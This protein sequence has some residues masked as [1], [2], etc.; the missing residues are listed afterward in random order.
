MT[1]LHIRAFV[2]VLALSPIAGLV[3]ALSSSIGGFS[4]LV[5]LGLAA[6]PLTLLATVS[7]ESFAAFAL[8]ATQPL[9][10]LQLP[11][12]FGNLT[13]GIGVLIVI[14]LRWHSEILSC[15]TQRGLALPLALAAAF[16]AGRLVHLFHSPLDVTLREFPQAASY[17]AAMAVGLWVASRR[18]LGYVAVG[19]AA[20]LLVMALIAAVSGVQLL[21]SGSHAGPARALF[22]VSSPLARGYGLP[23]PNDATALLLPLAVPWFVWVI[24]H[25]TSRRQRVAATLLLLSLSIAVVFVFQSR[26]MLL[27]LGVAALFGAALWGRFRLWVTATTV[28]MAM[29]VLL[30]SGQLDSV[31]PA[32]SELRLDGFRTAASLLTDG[33]EWVAV[34]TGTE[35]IY[36]RFM[37]L[38]YWGRVFEPGLAFQP[39]HNLILN[40]LVHS[41]IVVAGALLGLWAVVATRLW[42]V[43]DLVHSSPYWF[44]A[45]VGLAMTALA[46]QFDPISSN[47][48]SMWLVLGVAAWVGG[49]RVE[50]RATDGYAAREAVRGHRWS[51][52]NG[53]TSSRPARTAS[54][55]R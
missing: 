10:G 9:E 55:Q 19:A 52:A 50:A 30:L 25:A 6:V 4:S 23:L 3:S 46:T 48:I 29:G 39:I 45:A 1:R 26:S 34:G 28:S 21:D 54:G 47:V 22:G 35:V 53:M 41:G 37:A 13:I 40:E 31:D 18:R 16:L 49:V 36:D 43:R 14:L 42:R 15:T 38:S 2:A 11:I 24:R 20:S 17:F 51:P 7:S 33:P 44:A 32:S 27:Q 5:V 12:G 8:L